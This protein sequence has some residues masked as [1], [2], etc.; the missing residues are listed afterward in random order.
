MDEHITDYQLQGF[1]KRKLRENR[2]AYA[3]KLNSQIWC[4]VRLIKAP[5]HVPGV[6]LLSN[7][8]SAKIWGVQSCDSP[9]SCPVCSAKRMAHEAGRIA[10]AIDALKKQFN[11][12]A[13]MITLSVPHYHDFTCKQVYEILRETWKHFV[14]HAKSK[15]QQD[16]FAQMANDLQCKHRIRVGEFTWGHYGWHP[17][18]HCLFF[19]KKGNLQRALDWQDK[20]AARW[21]HLTKKS[22]IKILTRDKYRDMTKE[23][24]KEFVNEFFTKTNYAKGYPEAVIS[25]DENGKVR[26]AKSSE[27]ICGWGADKEL[28]GNVRKEASHAGHY[29]PHQILLKAYELYKKDEIEECDKWFSLYVEYALAT[30]KTYRV[31]MSPDLKKIIENWRLTNEYIECFKKKSTQETEETAW[32]VVCWF[33]EQQWFA[34]CTAEIL[35]Q[36]IQLARAPDA[37]KQISELLAKIGADNNLTEKAPNEEW[38]VKNMFNAA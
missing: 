19:V 4:A 31:R 8:T 17:H 32:K 20:L 11:E 26:R 9:W 3:K 37:R 25:L 29:T 12:E 18:Y 35:P 33:N 2:Y 10:S 38:F 27:Y 7:G 13:F 15:T 28:T 36:I 14:H 30:F 22:T 23:E 34:I 24:V 21:V 1:Y 5:R 16:V 6:F